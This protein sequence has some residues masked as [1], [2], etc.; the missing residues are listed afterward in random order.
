[1]RPG[2][3]D[4]RLTRRAFTL[5]AAA[6][7]VAPG[8]ALTEQGES[9]RVRALL[10]DWIDLRRQCLGASVSVVEARGASVLA[11]GV[12]GLHDQIGRAHV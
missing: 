9:A 12:R 8:P 2:S 4:G 1:M 6:A 7:L 3:F 5:S 11:H 10:A